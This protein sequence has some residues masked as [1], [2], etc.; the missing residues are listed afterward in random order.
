[1]NFDD[2]GK[3]GKTIYVLINDA[4]A[5]PGGIYLLKGNYRNTRTRCKIC[6]QLTIKTPEPR[7]WGLSGVFI[8]T[9]DIFHTLF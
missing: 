7:H 1:M 5:I 2:G 3:M 9:M 6:S 8:V 4:L